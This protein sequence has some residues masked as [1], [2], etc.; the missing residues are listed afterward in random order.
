MGEMRN[1]V[2]SSDG[3]RPLRRYRGRQEDI[4]KMYLK[5]IGFEGVQWIHLAQDS[6]QLQAFLKIVMNHHKM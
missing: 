4:I 3:K 2:E 6:V 5:E 1:A